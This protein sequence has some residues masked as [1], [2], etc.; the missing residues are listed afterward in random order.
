MVEVLLTTHL[1]T[2]IFHPSQEPV[3]HHNLPHRFKSP[4]EQNVFEE[5]LSDK[6]EELRK[7][8]YV[9]T[10]TV[11]QRRSLR[12]MFDQE[13]H[14][15]MTPIITPEKAAKREAQ[16][17]ASASQKKGPPPPPPPRK[18]FPG[19]SAPLEQDNKNG[20]R[21]TASSTPSP[22][23]KVPCDEVL[24]ESPYESVARLEIER[25]PESESRVDDRPERD[26]RDGGSSRNSKAL[27]ASTSADC[28]VNAGTTAVDPPQI[29]ST[30]KAQVTSKSTPALG[31]AADS[32]IPD[33]IGGTFHSQTL[34][35]VGNRGLAHSNGTAGKENATKEKSQSKRSFLGRSP[36]K[37]GQQGSGS[38]K[39]KSKKM[40]GALARL[41]RRD[42]EKGDSAQKAN[43]PNSNYGPPPKP[44]RG[45]MDSPT[46][47]AKKLLVKPASGANCNNN[48]KQITIPERNGQQSSQVTIQEKIPETS[49][50]ILSS[51]PE[52][53]LFP[54]EGI[55]NVQ[56]QQI[57]QDPQSPSS[58][59][60]CNNVTITVT[61]PKRTLSDVSEHSLRAAP[62]GAEAVKKDSEPVVRPKMQPVSSTSCEQED[63]K[64]Q[65]LKAQYA[66]LRQMQ[67]QN[68]VSSSQEKPTGSSE[69]RPSPKP[70]VAMIIK[71]G[72]Q[73]N[74]RSQPH[75][76][77]RNGA[78]SKEVIKL[79]QSQH[80]ISAT[81][82]S[83]LSCF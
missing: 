53:D 7:T 65:Q 10:N 14:D 51:S 26:E 71:P 22:Q 19:S 60:L 4:L 70:A 31:G 16:K 11:R 32:T 40:G 54:P 48:A 36:S 72:H 23:P 83:N 69:N 2:N 50:N 39:S 58:T 81:S 73:R 38:T 75:V 6:R 78:D 8:S 82:P 20:D 37:S 47:Q 28:L 13:D 33:T 79:I 21:S 74:A 63:L 67:M 43:S 61:T 66:R 15:A 18:H 46:Q 62:S 44:P 49:E 35:T 76:Q 52:Q 59:S 12:E 80:S 1:T 9:E 41:L 3:V 25:M 5:K 45:C 17:E 57:I 29:T 77:S 56:Q 68:K 55:Y 64:T 42:H 24:V 27:T 34:S 30:V